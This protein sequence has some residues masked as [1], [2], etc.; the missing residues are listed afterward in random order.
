MAKNDKEV[1][2]EPKLVADFNEDDY[3]ADR[4]VET[5]DGFTVKVKD[6]K[7]EYRTKGS[8]ARGRLRTAKAMN[9]SID[10][11][12]KSAKLLN[13]R[14]IDGIFVNDILGRMGFYNGSVLSR[15][16]LAKKLSV[17]VSAL[18]ISTE[19]LKEIVKHEDIKVAYAVYLNILKAQEDL[20]TQEEVQGGS[21]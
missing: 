20:V 13:N 1:K 11:L 19:K 7:K 8:T 10:H 2:K 16:D 6:V 17:E 4:E 18:E 21:N 9:V 3:A 5:K 14:K 15:S 12:V